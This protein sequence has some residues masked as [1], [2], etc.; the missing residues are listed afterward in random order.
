MAHHLKHMRERSTTKI[1]GQLWHPRLA[2]TGCLHVPTQDNFPARVSIMLH[3]SKHDFIDNAGYVAR[4]Q[5]G[6]IR[7]TP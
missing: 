7:I 6:I 4:L 5:W 3:C 1:I 2:Q